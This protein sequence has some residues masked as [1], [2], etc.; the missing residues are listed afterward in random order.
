MSEIVSLGQDVA[1][2]AATVKKERKPKSVSVNAAVFFSVALV[3]SRKGHSYREISERLNQMVKGCEMTPAKVSAKLSS[4]VPK[5]LIE[6]IQKNPKLAALKAIQFEQRDTEEGKKFFVSGGLNFPR[7]TR[8]VSDEDVTD[9]LS[10][11]EETVETE[12][13]E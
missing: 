3:A 11:L 7:S 10:E 1:E 9:I 5:S 8:H 2:L 13:K 4:P 6:E 12:T